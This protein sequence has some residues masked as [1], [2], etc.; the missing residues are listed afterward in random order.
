ML[1]CGK[2]LLGT[3][4]KDKIL[5]MAEHL[6]IYEPRL[7]GHHLTWLRYI[8]E[9][10]LSVGMKLTLAV[11]L[12]S[13]SRHLIEQKFA[14]LTDKIKIISA[15]A[16][17]EKYKGGSRTASLCLC[18]Q[19]SAAQEVF[20]PNFDEI[21]SATLRRAAF[22]IMPPQSLHR[23]LSGIYFRPRFMDNH[24]WPVG[25]MIKQLGFTRLCQGGWLNNL[26][27]L[28]E[29]LIDHAAD[30][31]SDCR[32]HFLP[33]VWS[34]DYSHNQKTAREKLQVPADKFVYLN[35]GIGTRRKGLH[36]ITKAMSNFELPEGA[37]LLCAGKIDDPELQRGVAELEKRG[38]A[39]VINR[40]VSDEEEELCF[41]ACNTVLL[42]YV[43]HFG[44]SGVL[45]RAAAAGKFVIVSD[46]GLIARRVR[47]H[48]L[49]LL[50]KPEDVE[51]LWN[52]IIEAFKI[53]KNQKSSFQD[54][55]YHYAESCSRAIF[56]TALSS[57]FTS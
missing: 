55:A 2:W 8:T 50:F 10:F 56:R 15:Y 13:G 21:A 1:N 54:S 48:N 35:Y 49:G 4:N 39:R 14:D 43:K 33:D 41:A 47:E 26:Y 20:M 18:L 7:G 24:Y 23:R 38:L 36:L 9:D 27:L 32:F 57:C 51:S 3:V 52:C 34:G 29:Y 28:D 12:R 40:Y 37:F 11:D 46:E 22:G 53:N 16:K 42:P 17:D 5:S 44:S 31:W 45:S 19:E 25:N 30:K 6:L